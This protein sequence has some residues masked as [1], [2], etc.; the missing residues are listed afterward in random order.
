VKVAI[1]ING[2]VYEGEVEP[3]TLLSDFIRHQAGLTGT[4][5]GCEHGVCGACTV[6]LD[7]EPVRSCLMLAIQ[8]DGRALRTVEGL[9]SDGQLHPLQRAFNETHALQCGFCTSGFLMALEAFLRERPDPSEEEIREA[10][11][12][13]LCRCTGY[14]AI[15]EAARRAAAELR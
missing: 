6:Q 9:A 11:S 2:S 13:N 3:R 4:R 14:V 1:E 15:V 7:G 8:A 12:G 5:V 10:L